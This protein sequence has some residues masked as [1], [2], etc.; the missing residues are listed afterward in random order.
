MVDL[1]PEVGYVHINFE[2]LVYEKATFI[3]V[4]K[5]TSKIKVGVQFIQEIQYKQKVIDYPLLIHHE[6]KI[7]KKHVYQKIFF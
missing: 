2:I 1:M 7:G 6:G 3:T 4:L 5:I